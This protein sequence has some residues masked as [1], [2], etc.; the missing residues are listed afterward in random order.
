MGNNETN[1]NN[2]FI[3]IIIF[4]LIIL[5]ILLVIFLSKN[6]EIIVNNDMPIISEE[7][8]AIKVKVST[9]IKPVSTNIIVNAELIPNE[10][11][12]IDFDEKAESNEVI[13][14]PNTGQN[15]VPNTGPNTGQNTVPNTGQ[16]T[17]PNTGPNTVPNTGQN[18]VPNTGQNTVPNTGQNTVPNTGQNTVPNTGQNT[19][20]NTGPNT[21]PNTGQNTGPNTVPNTSPNTGQNTVP[22]TG[23]N[24]V[25]NTKPIIELYEYGPEE[26]LYIEKISLSKKYYCR[27]QNRKTKRYIYYI[28]TEY[29]NTTS[30]DYVKPEEL[31]IPNNNIIILEE[32]LQNN[33]IIPETTNITLEPSKFVQPT[34]YNGFKDVI[35]NEYQ[36]L[37]ISLYN[38]NSSSYFRE[39]IK[40]TLGNNIDY[41]ITAFTEIIENEATYYDKFVIYGNPND[42]INFKKQYEKMNSSINGV[43]IPSSIN[44]CDS[45]DMYPLI[46]ELKISYNNINREIYESS[47]L[48]SSVL[49]LRTGSFKSNDKDEEKIVNDF[50]AEYVPNDKI[51]IENNFYKLYRLEGYEWND[52]IGLMNVLSSYPHIFQLSLHLT[53]NK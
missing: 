8:L 5:L 39:T 21:G 53:N 17:V 9:I 50:I 31:K 6:K 24:T 51:F 44:S 47:G 40:N 34:L 4:I 20:Q 48:L 2:Y 23:Q 27:K 7:D 16:N 12:T 11:S 38:L 28:R 10:Q 1:N 18:T 37:L 14:G 35:N 49:Y 52:I 32:K 45:L 41:Q 29:D 15:T 30:V 33:I 43:C 26:I 46:P 19:G 22:N 13:T 42:L 36:S 3:F 25:P